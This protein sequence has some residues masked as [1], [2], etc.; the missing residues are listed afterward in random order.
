MQLQSFGPGEL[1]VLGQSA[2]ALLA[3]VDPVG[4]VPLFL[5]FTADQTPRQRNRTALIASLVTA[6]ILIGMTLFGQFLLQMFGIRVAS[7]RVGGGLLLLLIGL[8]MLHSRLS[9]AKQTAEEQHEA[10]DATNVGVVPLAVPLMAGPGAIS[11]VISDAERLHGL[12]NRIGLMIVVM[13]VSLASWLILRMAEPVGRR[14][15]RTSI[16]V[17]TRLM[18]LVLV[19]IAV[20]MIAA[21]LTTLFPILAGSPAGR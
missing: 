19:A 9:G 17:I 15:R 3:I 18:G 5:S 12:T 21:G 11:L 20:E 2:I 13:V 1:M 6:V 4:N 7:M 14:M 8:A 10:V 16:N